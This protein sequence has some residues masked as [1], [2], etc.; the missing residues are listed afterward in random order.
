MVYV[1]IQSYILNMT[2]RGLKPRNHRGREVLALTYQAEAERVANNIQV[3]K[4]FDADALAE[5][6]LRGFETDNFSPWI[7]APQR[8]IKLSIDREIEWHYENSNDKVREKIRS[9][10]VSAINLWTDG[11]YKVGTLRKLG[12][13][14][15][16]PKVIDAIEPFRRAIEEKKDENPQRIKE[17]QEVGAGII[18]GFTELAPEK[19]KPILER[20]FFDPDFNGRTKAVLLNGLAAASPHEFPKYLPDFLEY[21]EEHPSYFISKFVIAVFVS[22]VGTATVAKHLHELPEAALQ[23]FLKLLSQDKSD[24]RGTEILTDKLVLKDRRS[25]EVYACE[26]ETEED[27]IKLQEAFRS[28]PKTN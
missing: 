5:L 28:I 6:F 15:G 16:C 17:K 8:H 18:S 1:I 4:T 23:K 12:Y 27:K 20:W 9:A 26:T 7:E 24:K 13:L 19:A 14:A 21:D 10:V 2:E 25:N 22:N 3:L 11:E